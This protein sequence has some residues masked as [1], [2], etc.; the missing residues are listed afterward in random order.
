MGLF[1]RIHR[2]YIVNIS[3]I[4]EISR[5]FSS[6]IQIT[7]KDGT[8]LPVSQTYSANVRKKLGF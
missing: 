1:I 2:S 7:L 8:V 6:N 5:D 4:K 3:Y